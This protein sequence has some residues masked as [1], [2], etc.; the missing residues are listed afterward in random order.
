ML[1]LLSDNDHTHCCLCTYYKLKPVQCWVANEFVRWSTPK[2]AFNVLSTTRL[3]PSLITLQTWGP[4]WSCKSINCLHRHLYVHYVNTQHISIGPAGSSIVLT[5]SSHM[6]TTSTFDVNIYYKPKAILDGSQ[7]LQLGALLVPQVYR[8]LHWQC[9]HGATQTG[10]RRLT[11]KVSSGNEVYQDSALDIGDFQYPG[12]RS[13]LFPLTLLL[14]CA[15]IGRTLL[16]FITFKSHH[17]IN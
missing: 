5:D 3:R 2:S 15:L 13:A 7:N 17:L 16:I 9:H 10:L 11:L 8:S 14:T 4:Y 6:F 12:R 1:W